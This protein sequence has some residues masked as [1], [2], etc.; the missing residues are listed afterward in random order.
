[1]TFKF[2]K[3]ALHQI[4]T[5]VVALFFFSNAAQFKQQAAL[6]T[7]AYGA[8]AASV[9]DTG[10]FKA[11]AQDVHV[12]YAKKGN[13]TIKVVLVGL[14]DRKKAT[15]ETYRRS[16]SAA[17]KKARSLKATSLAVWIPALR[18]NAPARHQSGRHDVIVAVC[19]G[20][21]LGTYTYDKYITKKNDAP[22]K[23]AELL[24]CSP[25]AAYAR[26][27][28]N[29]LHEAEANIAGTTLARDLA[30][31]PGNEIYPETLAQAA[32]DAAHRNNF[33]AKVLDESEIRE[34][35]MGGV[36]AVCRGS[37]HRPRLIVLEYGNPK[38]QPIV[39]V[40]K[41]VTFD[42]GGISIKPSAGMAEMKMDMSGAA[43]VIGTFETVARLKLPVHI[44]GVI[45]AVENMLSGS[46]FRPGDIVTHYNGMTSE[47]D[48]TD[49]EGRLILADALGYAET[50]KPSVVI[51][52][53]TLTGAVVVALGHHAT[54]LMGNDETLMR[55]LK[56][57][58][59]KTYERV[60]RLPL[61][62]EYEKQ[63][64]SDVADVKNV[65]G[66]WGGAITAAWFLKKFIGKYK[67]A[68]LDIAGTAIIEEPQD[69]IP[70]GGSGVGAR[71]L[72]EFLRHWK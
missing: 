42:S 71:L 45:P 14:G 35:N 47:I 34:L 41:G 36:L 64:K 8:H 11:K 22:P 44:I 7:R 57:A 39:L 28:T 38:K 60:W 2:K 15:L 66:R 51:D 18:G 24:L 31:A 70:K 30:N 10:D 25:D 26:V 33:S 37:A 19:E 48:D 27:A 72:T 62:D 50:F 59:E 3:T 63:I 67:W 21:A 32:I 69:Y 23:L 43:A 13:R 53:A 1:M 4:P 6:L 49:A 54:G 65:G 68:H 58:G 12:V 5:D 40:G 61:F 56:H 16:A 52:L 20:A 29:A 9:L 17:A 46:S 55:A